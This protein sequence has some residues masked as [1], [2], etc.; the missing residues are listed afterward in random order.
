MTTLKD[1][2]P[3]ARK[4]HSCNFCG[5]VIRKGNIYNYQVNV[6]EGSMYAWKTHSHCGEIASKLN[7]YDDYSEG[8]NDDIFNEFIR[9]EYHTI[10]RDKEHED[11]KRTFL[12]MLQFVCKH[13]LIKL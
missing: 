3:K 1:N 12:Q 7:M 9:D 13:H 11:I 10:M 8:V 4:D 2:K 6:Y 5:G